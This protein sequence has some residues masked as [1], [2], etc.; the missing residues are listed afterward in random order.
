MTDTVARILWI[1]DDL[2]LASLFIVRMQMEGFVVRHCQDGEAGLE[3]LKD[4]SP[5]L[6]LLDLMMPR[7]SGFDVLDTIRHTAGIAQPKVVILSAMGQPE[8][9]DKALKLGADDYLVKSRLALDDI[10]RAIRR[11]L[12]LPENASKTVKV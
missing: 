10:I 6:V 12:G 9:R 3:A 4:F 7:V 5:D 2:A 11:D 1:E 8:D